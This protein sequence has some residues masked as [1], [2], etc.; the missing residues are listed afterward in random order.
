M[1]TYAT[2]LVN[3]GREFN[4]TFARFQKRYIDNEENIFIKYGNFNFLPIS[5]VSS[6]SSILLS[7]ACVG[8]FGDITITNSEWIRVLTTLDVDKSSKFWNN[9]INCTHL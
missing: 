2:A 5:V 9:K 6:N 1:A 3:D 7:A 4:K 8:K